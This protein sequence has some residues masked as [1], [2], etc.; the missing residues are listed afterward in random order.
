[1]H[2]GQQEHS[3]MCIF[4]ASRT[5]ILTLCKY[6]YAIYIASECGLNRFRAQFYLLTFSLYHLGSYG[7]HAAYC[8]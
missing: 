1:M 8:M 2:V 7:S 6:C 5:R 4:F 3:P